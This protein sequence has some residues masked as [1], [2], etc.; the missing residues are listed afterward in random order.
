MKSSAE[1]DTVQ[2]TAA[3]KEIDSKST[4][5]DV[6]KA[7]VEVLDLDLVGPANDHAFA[8]ELLP[9]TPLRW[10]LTGFLVPTD[11]PISQKFDE[12][13]VEE[14]DSAEGDG[15][16]TRRSVIWDAR[17]H[18]VSGRVSDQCASTG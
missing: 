17:E 5:V 10:Y 1:K 16:S 3:I 8:R 13:S 2:P 15:D 14:I 4:S 9:E 12:S 6:R 11:A 7:L 18:E